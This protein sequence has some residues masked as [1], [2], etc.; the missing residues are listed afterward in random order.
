MFAITSLRER[1]HIYFEQSGN[2]EQECSR[3]NPNKNYQGE[4]PMK[5]CIGALIVLVG[6]TLFQTALAQDH[7]RNWENGNIVAVSEV[8]IEDGMFNAY[9]NDLNQ[10][11]RRFLELQ[12][13]DGDV[14]SYGMYAMANS[15]EGEPDLIL[16]V[17][18]K[19]WAAFD[20]GVE[21]FEELGER[22]FGSTDDMRTAN[23]DRGAMRTI[24]SSYILQQ[25]QFE[26]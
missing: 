16:T 20:R 18:Y 7:E 23:V 19:N 15:R 8:H 5:K 24:G 9:I 13:E 10:G 26:D 12:K 2:D 21:Y 14:V 3:R 6:A 22:I 25:I 1:V 17:T 11:W 4:E